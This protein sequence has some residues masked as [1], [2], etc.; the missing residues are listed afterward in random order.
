MESKVGNCKCVGAKE[1]RG[2][3][4]WLLML[5]T[6]SNLAYLT[7]TRSL[8]SLQDDYTVETATWQ[9]SPHCYQSQY[10][11]TKHHNNFGIT[12]NFYNTHFGSVHNSA[13]ASIPLH[14]RMG[15]L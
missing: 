11:K 3:K 1:V 2:I 9:W 10:H 13:C 8:N 7:Q 4:S 12:K 5:R 14:L 15:K 6:R